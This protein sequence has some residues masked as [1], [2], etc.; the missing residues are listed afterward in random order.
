M[1]SVICKLDHGIILI[2]NIVKTRATPVFEAQYS[3]TDLILHKS[4]INNYL[5]QCFSCRLHSCP[6]FN[7]NKTGSFPSDSLTFL[8]FSSLGKKEH[9]WQSVWGVRVFPVE[10]LLG[11]G[12]RGKLLLG[13]FLLWW[14]RIIRLKHF[15][16]NPWHLKFLLWMSLWFG[17]FMMFSTVNASQSSLF[18]TRLAAITWTHSG[19]GLLVLAGC[20]NWMPTL[21]EEACK[22]LCAPTSDW[23][24]QSCPFMY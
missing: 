1:F 7:L 2:S 3:T 15:T 19:V 14:N 9:L 20:V 16:W 5:P 4:G 23:W 22:C 24:Q 21:S 10:L 17:M 6:C 12:E 8:S 18:T 13:G 11:R